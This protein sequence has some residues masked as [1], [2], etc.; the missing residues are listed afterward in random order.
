MNN[1][2]LRI[3]NHKVAH[4]LFV[5]ELRYSRCGQNTEPEELWYD[6]S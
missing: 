5:E 4:T 6:F 1:Y 3:S 2:Q